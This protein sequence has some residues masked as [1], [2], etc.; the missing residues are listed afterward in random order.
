MNKATSNTQKNDFSK[1]SVA[2][3]ILKLAVPMTL[4]QL[5]NVLYST[6]DRIY[7]GHLPNASTEALTGIGLTLPIITIITAF[8]NLFGM[9]GGPLFSIERGRGDMDRAGRIMGNSFFMMLFSGVLLMILC[10]LF[11]RP[12]LYLFG[13]SDQTYP[14]ASAYI[15]IYLCGTLFVMISLGMNFFINAQGFGMIGM[16]TVSIGAVLNLILDPF[17]I[18]GLNAGVRGAAL[19]TILSQAVSAIWVLRFLTGK[20][21]IVPLRLSLMKPDFS[22]IR[23]ISTL[24][25]AGFMMSITNGSVQIMCNAVLSHYGGDLYVGIMTV[26]NSVR[27]IVHMPIQGLTNGGQPVMSFN[28]GARKYSRV[29]SAIRFT[30]AWCFFFSTLLGL[31]LIL[32]PEFFI[33]L[34]N[35]DPGLLQAGVPAMR[36]YF[37]GMFMMS[38]QFAGQSIF[39]A[40]GKSRQAVFFSL[41][42]KAIIVIPLTLWLPTVA[43]LG[44]SGVF[45]AEPVSNFIG[46]TACFVTMIFTVWKKLPQ[47]SEATEA[48][49]SLESIDSVKS[50]K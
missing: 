26:I 44:T 17:F 1:G 18:F 39:T 20:R 49:E 13:A 37:F 29:K 24:G 32:F 11:K 36:I 4:A 21:A 50:V 31:I 14:F 28:Y 48:T 5:I 2:G 10:N 46:G 12:M 8:T 47:D 33:H 3:N 6:I 25:L 23:E 34:F 9:G 43:G 7:I 30:T 27:E 41:L 22:L 35:S 19:A 16:L 40:L 38:F 15:T 45:L 42:R